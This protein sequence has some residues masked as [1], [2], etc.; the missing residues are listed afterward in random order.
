MNRPPGGEEAPESP[1][2]WES[3]TQAFGDRIEEAFRDPEA[4]SLGTNYLSEVLINWRESEKSLSRAVTLIV[5]TSV[6]AVL[7][8][9]GHVSEVS[10][11]GIKVTAL[12]WLL[13]ALPVVIAYLY[14]SA[15]L[16]VAES[17][18]MMEA[19]AAVVTAL[20]GAG[21]PPELELPLYP[22]NMTLFPHAKVNLALPGDSRTSSLVEVSSFFRILVVVLTP[23]GVEI[24]F[25]YRA[26]GAF[27]ADSVLLW[28]SA[29]SAAVLLLT[30]FVFL[31]AGFRISNPA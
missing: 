7:V 5:L 24:Y 13:L 20:W 15:F 17:M 16:H 2:Y 31:I 30:G 3:A 10:I 11:L 9:Q 23:V 8:A 25:Y 26:Y 4:K 19:F 6:A 18:T 22:G 1:R 12:R 14:S 21:H 28:L 27:A 29:A